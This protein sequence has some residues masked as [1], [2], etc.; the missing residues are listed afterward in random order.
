M[1]IYI[2]KIQTSVKRCQKSLY[3]YFFKTKDELNILEEKFEN[4]NR[5]L[6]EIL[7]NL[8]YPPVKMVEIKNHQ[9]I[10]S[11]II[12]KNASFHQKINDNKEQI[13]LLYAKNNKINTKKITLNDSKD[14]EFYTAAYESNIYNQELFKKENEKFLEK[15][16]IK[17]I[18]LNKDIVSII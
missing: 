3:K 10:F 6:E 11:Q 2:K 8:I 7:N 17:Y 1:I 18:I 9:S 15:I 13:K 12:K 16:H 4:I 5:K 14:L